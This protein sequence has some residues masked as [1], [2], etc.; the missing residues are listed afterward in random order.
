MKYP[1]TL[2]LYFT[3]PKRKMV[4]KDF[5]CA[6]KVFENFGEVLFARSHR[7]DSGID[8]YLLNMFVSGN[9]N[10]VVDFWRK[11]NDMVPDNLK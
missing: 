5:E 2:R 1:N 3:E 9:G 11:D 10:M 6:K 8:Y 4:F 7:C